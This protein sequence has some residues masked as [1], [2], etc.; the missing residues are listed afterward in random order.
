MAQL[1]PETNSSTK[2]QCSHQRVDGH[3]RMDSREAFVRSE[4][5]DIIEEPPTDSTPIE[6]NG[7]NGSELAS[8]GTKLIALQLSTDHNTIIE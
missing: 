7:N 4:L 2:K 5:E 1:G 6:A 8:P 3:D